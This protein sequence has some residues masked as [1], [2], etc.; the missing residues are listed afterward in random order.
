MNIGN[1]MKI[2]QNFGENRLEIVENFN[3]IKICRISKNEATC[4]Q[5]FAR[6]DKNEENF[7]KISRKI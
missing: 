7:E 3:I 1:G 2:L 6:L 4:V 5:S